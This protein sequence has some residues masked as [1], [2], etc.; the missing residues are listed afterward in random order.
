MNVL[1]YCTYIH[2]MFSHLLETSWNLQPPPLHGQVIDIQ[3]CSCLGTFKSVCHLFSYFSEITKYLFFDYFFAFVTLSSMKKQKNEWVY[4][5]F[6]V[7][8]EAASRECI[9]P[10]LE[11]SDKVTVTD[12]NRYSLADIFKQAQIIFVKTNLILFIIVIN[13]FIHYNV[14]ALWCTSY[15]WSK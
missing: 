5:I 12:M 4:T 2:S 3:L 13:Y 15:N 6:V 9:S 8:W 1:Y 14:L 10:V 11:W 7:S